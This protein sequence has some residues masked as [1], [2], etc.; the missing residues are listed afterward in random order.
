MLTCFD[1][2]VLSTVGP[3]MNTFLTR[4]SKH[5]NPIKTVYIPFSLADPCVFLGLLAL[6]ARVYAKR[7]GD[8][9]F[10]VT[11]LSYTTQCIRM[12]NLALEDSRKAASDATIAAVLMLA[13]AEVSFQSLPGEYCISP[14]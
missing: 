9:S 2:A 1:F 4:S 10:H 12:V 6:T 7:S 13:V 8:D 14:C 11:A 5:A 3:G